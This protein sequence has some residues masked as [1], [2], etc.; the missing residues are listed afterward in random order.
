[1]AELKTKPTKVSVSGFLNKIPDRQRRADAIAVADMM[2][3]VTKKEPKMWGTSIVGFGDY[4]YKYASGREGD[5]FAMGVSPRKDSLT[6]YICRGF[7][8][9][10]ELMEKLGKYKTGMSCLYIRKLSDV[11]PG[12][13]KKLMT[14]AYKAGPPTFG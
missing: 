11:D 9:Y 6:V 5:W 14:R 3:A 13:L 10:P 4:H 1:M 8:E 7:H 2:K 12:V